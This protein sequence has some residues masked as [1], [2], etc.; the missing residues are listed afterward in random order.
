LLEVNPACAAFSCGLNRKP[1]LGAEGD[2]VGCCSMVGA[3][4]AGGVEEPKENA[5]FGG[6]ATGSTGFCGALNREAASEEPPKIGGGTGTFG[7]MLAALLGSLGGSLLVT[8]KLKT[9]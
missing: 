9:G 4:R 1:L 8:P 5:G 2:F 7:V 3:A 6:S